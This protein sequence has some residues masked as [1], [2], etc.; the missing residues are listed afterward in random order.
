MTDIQPD[1]LNGDLT[2]AAEM[3]TSEMDWVRSP[4]PTVWRKRLDHI[5]PAEAGRVTSLVRFELGAKFP[6][7]IIPTARRSWS[8]TGCSR[9]TPETGA[10]AA[11]C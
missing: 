4:T 3:H 5:G 9:T 2:R 11:F 7:T 8:S 1:A 6:R 10:P